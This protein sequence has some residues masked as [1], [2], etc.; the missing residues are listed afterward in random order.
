MMREQN[1]AA[2]GSTNMDRVSVNQEER[3]ATKDSDATKKD[4]S[5]SGSASGNKS[6]SQGSGKSDQ[7]SKSK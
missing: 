6:G 3:M 2:D 4:S 1:S 7:G 5:K